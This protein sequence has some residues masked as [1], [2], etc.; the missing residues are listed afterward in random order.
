MKAPCDSNVTGAFDFSGND[1]VGWCR[2]HSSL[3]S[4]CLWRDGMVRTERKRRIK[5]LKRAP[6]SRA[7]HSLKAGESVCPSYL[8]SLTSQRSCWNQGKHHSL[9]PQLLGNLWR[10]IVLPENGI[11]CICCQWS[12]QV[13]MFQEQAEIQ[14]EEGIERIEMGFWSST[15]F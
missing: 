4:A 5:I 15:L 13:R 9:A 12:S 1:E 2:C 3:H 8:S 14:M 6:E 11:Y 7:A 10:K